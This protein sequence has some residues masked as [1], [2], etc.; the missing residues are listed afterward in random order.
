[1]SRPGLVRRADHRDEPIP[2]VQNI[3]Y[4][5]G[6][7][8]EIEDDVEFRRRP[9]G[10]VSQPQT[11]DVSILDDHHFRFD[12]IGDALDHENGTGRVRYGV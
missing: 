11:G 12:P 5:S 3:H 7:R 2:G 4:L 8:C 6:V 10:G 1:M 9:V